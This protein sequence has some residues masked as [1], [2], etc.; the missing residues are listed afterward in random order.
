MKALF[1]K[2]PYAG[3]IIAG[4][5]NI[6]NRSWAPK[7][8]VGPLAICSSNYPD[9]G[10]RWDE[11][12]EKCRRLGV[13]FPA[14]LCNIYG[15]VVGVVDFNFFVCK[16]DDGMIGTDHHTIEATEMMEWWNVDS[17]GFILE[18]PRPLDQPVPIKG[19][20]GLFDLPEDV[21]ADIQQQLQ[22]D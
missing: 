1:V 18:N 12:R 16:T 15:A 7:E 6:E 22:M 13:S 19:Q 11:V 9:T 20:P 2:Q 8:T 4:I 10:K 3:L 17:F 21:L 14:D 5:K